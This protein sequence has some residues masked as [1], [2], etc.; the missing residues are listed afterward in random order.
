MTKSELAEH[1]PTIRTLAHPFFVEQGETRVFAA[2]CCGRL[3]VT[4][5]APTAC[6]T[7]GKAIV[8]QTIT[9]DDVRT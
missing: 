7:C 3:F 4:V 5:N 2:T 1:M 8:P 6:R 9:P